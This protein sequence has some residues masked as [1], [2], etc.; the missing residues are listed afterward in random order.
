MSQNIK[1]RPIRPS[2]KTEWLRMRQALWPDESTDELLEEIAHI[3]AAIQLDGPPDEEA[4]FVCLRPE[5]GLCGFLEVSIRQSAPGCRTDRI[6]YLEGWY[7][8]PDWRGRGVG[9]ALVESGEAWAR[10]KGCTEMASD[11]DPGYPLSPGAHAA[12]GYAEVERYFRK[13]L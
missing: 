6:G 10:S 1:I 7:V 5:G 4:A 12:L 11:T 3:L 13:D 9:R 8:D 2:D